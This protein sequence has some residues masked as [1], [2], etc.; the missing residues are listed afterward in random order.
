MPFCTLGFEC[1]KRTDDA[2]AACAADGKFHRHERKTEDEKEQK[3]NKNE[4]STTVLSDDVWETPYIAKTD[5][6]ARRNQNEPEAGTNSSLS[7]M[8]NP[9][10]IN[11]DGFIIA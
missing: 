10:K 4:C 9:L 11:F 2:L 3:I 6:T 5:G 8:I 1:F 7:M